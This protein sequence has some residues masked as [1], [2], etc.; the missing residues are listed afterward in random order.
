MLY[1]RV[2][3]VVGPILLSIQFREVKGQRLQALPPHRT[4]D[5]GQLVPARHDLN[6]WSMIELGSNDIDLHQFNYV[7]WDGVNRNF[8]RKFD[9]RHKSA[10]CR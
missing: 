9:Q 3:Q 10:H 8:I 4:G 7:R 5:R 6:V 1:F 2:D